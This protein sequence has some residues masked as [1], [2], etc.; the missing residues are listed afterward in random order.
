MA[1]K[2]KIYAEPSAQDIRGNVIV[3]PKWRHRWR[4]PKWNLRIRWT[5]R[6]YG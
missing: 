6:Q 2:G 1:V 3:K 5:K 4:K